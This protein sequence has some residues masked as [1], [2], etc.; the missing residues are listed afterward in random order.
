MATTVEE[1]LGLIEARIEESIGRTQRPWF[2][3]SLEEARARLASPV[4][5]GPEDV[6]RLHRV[7]GSFDGPE[8]LAEHMREY[9]SGRRD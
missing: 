4:E 9:A 1:R 5:W 8:D 6:E 2:A 7:Y 3:V